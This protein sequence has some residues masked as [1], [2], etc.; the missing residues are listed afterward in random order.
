MSIFDKPF[1]SVLDQ[2]ET[3]LTDLAMLRTSGWLDESVP[4]DYDETVED[5]YEDGGD[6]GC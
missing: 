1:V 3:V 2:L 6:V 5:E 4:K